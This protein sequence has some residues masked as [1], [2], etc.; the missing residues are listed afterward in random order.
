MATK[1]PRFFDFL[2]SSL[3][4][5]TTLGKQAVGYQAPSASRRLILLNAAL[6]SGKLKPTQ[7]GTYDRHILAQ[8]GNKLEQIKQIKAE[9]DGGK[10]FGGFISNL[11]GDKGVWG[12]LRGLPMGAYQYGKSYL[13]D[14]GNDVGDIFSGNMPRSIPVPVPGL[15]IPISGKSDVYKNIVKPMAKQYSYYY[16]GEGAPKGQSFLDRV[17]DNPA[18]LLLDV[19]SVAS[20]G[21]T[22][23]GRAGGLISRVGSAAEMG[24]AGRLTR[25]TGGVLNRTPLRTLGERASFIT[26]GTYRSPFKPAV[27]ENTRQPLVIRNGL[28]GV[29]GQLPSIPRAYSR[30]PTFKL[31]QIVGDRVLEGDKLPDAIRQVAENSTRKRFLRGDYAKDEFTT[32]QTIRDRLRTVKAL[33]S[34]SDAELTAWYELKAGVRK[35]DLPLWNRA[36]EQSIRGV[37]PQHENL[38]DYPV[39][40]EAI[41][42]QKLDP[43]VQEFIKNPSERMLEFNQAWEKVTAD[44][45]DRLSLDPNLVLEARYGPRKRILEHHQFPAEMHQAAEVADAAGNELR[46]HARMA[47]GSLQQAGQMLRDQPAPQVTSIV[48]PEIPPAQ[49]EALKTREAISQYAKDPEAGTYIWRGVDDVPEVN[50]DVGVHWTADPNAALYRSGDSPTRIWEA[51][52]DDPAKQTVP[53]GHPMWMGKH[54]SMEWEAE[55]RLRPGTRVRVTGYWSWEGKGTP[56]QFYL[57]AKDWKFTPVGKV[58]TANLPPEGISHINYSDVTL[59]VAEKV[60]LPRAAVEVIADD[61]TWGPFLDKL[62]DPQ[63]GDIV[64]RDLGQKMLAEMSRYA[65][66]S[67]EEYQKLEAANVKRGRRPVES[68]YVP[69]RKGTG[70]EEYEPGLFGRLVRKEPGVRQIKKTN[71]SLNPQVVTHENAFRPPSEAWLHPR[72][73]HSVVA[74]IYRTDKRPLLDYLASVE[75]FDAAIKSNSH[76]L[77]L[78]GLKNADGEVQYFRDPAELQAWEYAHSGKHGQYALVPEDLPYKF[79]TQEVKVVENLKKLLEGKGNLDAVDLANAVNKYLDEDGKEF[80]LNF[81]GAAK[82]RM[83]AVDAKALKY[84]LDQLNQSAPFN[85]P[86]AR[87]YATLMAKWRTLALAYMPRWWVNTAVG[88]AFMNVMRGVVNPRDYITAMKVVGRGDLPAGV[89]M[90]FHGVEA[91]GGPEGGHMGRVTAIAYAAPQR[92]EDYFR[93]AAFVQRLKSNVRQRIAEEGSIIDGYEKLKGNMNDE[94][95]YKEL[96]RPNEDGTYVHQRL[97]DYSLEEVNHFAYNY[98]LLGPMERRYIRQAIPFWGWYRFVTKLV[99]TMPLRAPVRFNLMIHLGMIGQGYLDDITVG[100]P[101]PPWMRGI[102]ALNTDRKALEYLST[103][104]VNPFSQWFNPFASDGMVTLAQFSPA[105]QTGLNAIGIDTYKQ[106]PV[107]ASPFADVQAVPGIAGQYVNVKTGKEATPGENNIFERLI[108]GAMRSVPQIR[109]LEQNLAA[110]GRSVYPESIPF[111]DTKPM[112]SKSADRARDTSLGGI[113]EQFTGIAQ[114]QEN[115]DEYEKKLARKVK[116]TRTSTEKA[117]KNYLKRAAEQGVTP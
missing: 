64:P 108:G 80:H 61:P 60:R 28:R 62:A 9:R 70:F 30:S 92:I 10:D 71:R 13:S 14:L 74:G 47:E 57:G 104:G 101:L 42:K 106:G 6:E 113:L 54:R 76:F 69:I 51:V 97:I 98:N 29:D 79:F 102:V 46:A 100:M 45:P 82:A 48:K 22:G 33:H 86:A 103:F 2:G 32:N 40:P 50:K 93:T 1:R 116:A 11:L 90:G 8:Y 49:A 114:R 16:G 43:A 27:V 36:R 41:V 112:I 111:I 38:G 37:N 77:D 88:T 44:H 115:I 87:A 107:T 55:V 21:A 99:W 4:A 105:I 75:K 15:A 66:R 3:P 85:N 18:Q 63:L 24:N 25:L 7:L 95:F 110:G 56:T 109:I 23:A 68:G 67:L 73:V 91:M 26:S 81:L 83:V 84:R 78:F 39:V 89:H 34:L 59:P 117:R 96:F 58:K 5:G 52:V 53:R 12:M 17:Y 31:L 94:S 72:D 20:G 19:A 65:E 35:G